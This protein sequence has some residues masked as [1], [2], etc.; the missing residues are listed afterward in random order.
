[1]TAAPKNHVP[2][3]LVV[4]DEQMIADTLR[5]ILA[6][7]GFDARAAYS[8]EAA[9]E[10]ARNFQPD[11]LLTDVV[12]PGISGIEAA[13][14]M[15]EILPSCKVLLISGQAATEDLLAQ[16]RARDF[17]FELLTKPVHPRE[18]IAKLREAIAA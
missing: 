2:K 11:A 15:S 16:A 7:S 5:E 8:G 6:H 1:M 14:E 12:M 10:V 18:L 3:V 4:D 9:L 17:E 13:I